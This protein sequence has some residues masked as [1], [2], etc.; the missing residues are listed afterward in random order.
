MLSP[1]S[2]WFGMFGSGRKVGARS[3]I[4]ILSWLLLSGMVNIGCNRKR[5]TSTEPAIPD[6]GQPTGEMKLLTGSVR[7][8]E[9][10]Q[11]AV[12][13][14][15]TKAAQLLG[16]A[17][18][19][20][21]E[22]REKSYDL[23]SK[24]LKDPAARIAAAEVTRYRAAL[25][26]VDEVS[27]Q[28]AA[29]PVPD[30]LPELPELPEKPTY[31]K[32]EYDGAWLLAGEF[33]GRYKDGEGIVVQRGNKYYIVEDGSV[34]V[35]R[36]IHGFVVNTGGVEILAIGRDGRTAD[37]VRLSDR[38]TYYEDQADYRKSVAEAKQE[39][40]KALKEYEVALQKRKRAESN[41]EKMLSSRRAQEQALQKKKSQLLLQVAMKLFAD[42]NENPNRL[43]A[44]SEVSADPPPRAGVV[45]SGEKLS[46]P[47]TQSIR[48]SE[49]IADPPQRAGTVMIGS[50]LSQ[51]M[52]RS[53]TVTK[54]AEGSAGP[55]RSLPR[56]P[57]S[58]AQGEGA[59]GESGSRPAAQSHD[60]ERVVQGNT[61]R[62]ADKAQEPSDSFAQAQRLL[63]SGHAR[64]AQ[65]IYEELATT[66]SDELRVQMGL[67]ACATATK[68]YSAAIEHYNEALVMAP[69]HPGAM[70]GIADT[71][72]S[73]GD[74]EHALEWY[75][76]YLD[77][78]AA[79]AHAQ[80][81][82]NRIAALSE[83]KSG[84]WE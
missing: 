17:A 69:D 64:E 54:A 48:A 68:H 3:H 65:Q 78:H 16:K 25:A 15:L 8:A 4:L 20:T 43:R 82:R 73:A 9:Q 66:H 50:R 81:A 42:F 34:P 7:E 45:M 58:I 52:T 83:K 74:V 2:G 5:A 11:K 29:L 12:L 35:F 70:I 14:S 46:Q 67:G 84:T 47:T 53:A 57:S 18:Q 61:T 22:D 23:L 13:E 27:K 71:Y 76:K 51:P 19:G 36:Y 28:L 75:R 38:E 37:V 21:P 60:K 30:E 63:T 1:E 77:T 33:R 41:A 80:K 55:V 39:F 10:E 72:A 32:P 24:T 59:D 31:E 6:L 49:V 40:G 56:L 62:D 79:G 44:I 26:Q